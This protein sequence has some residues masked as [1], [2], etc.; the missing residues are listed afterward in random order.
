MSKQSTKVLKQLRADLKK[1]QKRRPSLSEVSRERLQAITA[2]LDLMKLEA[3][4][5]G[6]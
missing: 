3:E 1:L 2:Q 4:K 5:N 6:R